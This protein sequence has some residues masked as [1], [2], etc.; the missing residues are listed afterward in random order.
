MDSPASAP[1]KRGFPVYALVIVVVII[2]VAAV[3]LQVA[4]QRVGQ[5]SWGAGGLTPRGVAL[6]TTRAS[7]KS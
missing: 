5:A 7:G 2:I 3:A 6:R 4:R 1:P